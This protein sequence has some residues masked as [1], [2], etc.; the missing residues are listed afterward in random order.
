MTMGMKWSKMKQGSRSRFN[1]FQ[2]VIPTSIGYLGNCTLWFLDLDM[3]GFYFESLN[4]KSPAQV[5]QT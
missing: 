3:M 2:S 1:S 4:Q 5:R